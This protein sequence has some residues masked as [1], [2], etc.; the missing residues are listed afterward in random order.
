[1][2]D[3]FTIF[4]II[5]FSI[6]IAICIVLTILLLIIYKVGQAN[7]QKAMLLV[8]EAK[9][10]LKDNHNVIN[11]KIIH[12]SEQDIPMVVIRENENIT[13][14]KIPDNPERII[15][16]SQAISKIKK[17]EGSLSTEELDEIKK[18]LS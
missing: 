3:N 13:E 12:T 11:F 18:K 7:Y 15:Q 8:Q 9:Q 17:S 14:I 5:L 1:M 4:I 10:E 16:I 2:I 6:L